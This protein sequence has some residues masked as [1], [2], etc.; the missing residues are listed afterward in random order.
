MHPNNR[1]GIF[2]CVLVYVSTMSAQASTG[3]SSCQVWTALL[4]AAKHPMRARPPSDRSPK[5]PN[6]NLGTEDPW[7]INRLSDSDRMVAIKCFLGLEGDRRPASISGATQFE[8]SQTF[9]QADV[10]LAALYAVSYLYLGEYKHA[11]AVA[12]RGAGASS[13]DSL[14]RYK[15]RRAAVRK[16]FRY[17][18]QWFERVQRVG[19][20]EAR[21][22]QLRPL[23]G[24]GLEWYGERKLIGTGR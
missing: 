16:A 17:Y 10:E 18:R 19:L 14:G 4:V 3:R 12:L 7:N 5:A 24:S 13:T 9:V 23:E 2:L 15:T 20:S 22:G 6:T 8:T 1:I 21:S 11:S